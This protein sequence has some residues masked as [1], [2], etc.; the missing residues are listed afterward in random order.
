MEPLLKF[1]HYLTDHY[2]SAEPLCESVFLAQKPPLRPYPLL[3]TSTSTMQIIP[4]DFQ[5][6]WVP[7]N[8]SRN[9][10]HTFARLKP[11]LQPKFLGPKKS[12]STQ[13]TCDPGSVP[14]GCKIWLWVAAG[15][16]QRDLEGNQDINLIFFVSQEL[17][18]QK[19]CYLSFLDR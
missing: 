14:P 10:S 8:I 19:Y 5:S 9:Y 7:P 6:G 17:A 11:V 1:T 3:P 2:K 13:T 16:T 18:K 15:H 12:S 4:R